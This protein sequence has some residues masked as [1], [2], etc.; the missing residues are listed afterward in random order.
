[1]RSSQYPRQGIRFLPSAAYRQRLVSSSSLLIKMRVG[2]TGRGPACVIN[3]IKETAYLPRY[4]MPMC[5][6]EKRSS[7]GPVYVRPQEFDGEKKQARIMK[8]FSRT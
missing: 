3:V 8:A 1:M 2:R 6:G 7:C 5:L 4:K